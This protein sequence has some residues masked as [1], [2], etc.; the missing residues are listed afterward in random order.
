MPQKSPLAIVKEKF[1]EKSKL[2]E[3]IKA[4]G[5]EELWLGRTSSDRGKDRDLGN[6]SN[7][8]LLRLHAI[9]TDVKKQFGSRAKLIE[10]ILESQKR[11]KDAGYK[12]RLEAYPVPRLFDLYKTAKKRGDRAAKA[13][14]AKG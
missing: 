3:A 7:A 1:G 10:G 6:V 9:F 13:A 8:N 5:T 12:A 2:L 4:F 14:A 11:G